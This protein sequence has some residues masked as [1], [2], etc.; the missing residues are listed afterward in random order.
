[1]ENVEKKTIQVKDKDGILK[2]AEVVLY[3]NRDDKDFIIYTFNEK[4]PN[5]MII[6]YSSMVVKKDDKITFEKIEND[7]W[8]KVKQI[9][10]KI[11]KEWS[12]Q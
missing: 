3:F 10:N 1:M 8:T 4:D 7:D 5:G 6:L 12:E 9:M 2:E 11:V